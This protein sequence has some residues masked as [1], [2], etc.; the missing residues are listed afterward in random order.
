MLALAG[1]WNV[2][3]V[4]GLPSRSRR[5]VEGVSVAAI[6]CVPCRRSAAPS[7]RQVDAHD[8]QQH[9]ERRDR[10]PPRRPSI[11]A[12]KTRGK[13]ADGV[14]DF[15]VTAQREHHAHQ[16]RAVVASSPFDERAMGLV[17][18]GA[19]SAAAMA[20]GLPRRRHAHRQVLRAQ[21]LP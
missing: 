4:G 15:H 9:S 2:R 7:D 12:P 14:D 10:R 19:V 1:T 16:N 20:R 11:V 21:N 13:T 17:N 18:V 5:D 6:T 8:D 3:A